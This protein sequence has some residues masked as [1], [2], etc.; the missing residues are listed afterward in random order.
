[1]YGLS[2]A[3]AANKA[4]PF[5]V[6]VR[7]ISRGLRQVPEERRAWVCANGRRCS[8][9]IGH[10]AAAVC[11]AVRQGLSAGISNRSPANRTSKDPG[12]LR[13]RFLL[14]SVLRCF[15][16][17]FSANLRSYAFSIPR[18]YLEYRRQRRFVYLD[19]DVLQ[20]LLQP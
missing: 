17:L 4:I 8:Y 5:P 6:R 3:N 15:Q 11:C 18:N 14:C 1:R 12:L 10:R 7:G 19:D 9:A 2:A 13:Y 20:G 16:P